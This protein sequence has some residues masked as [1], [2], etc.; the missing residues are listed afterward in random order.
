MKSAEVGFDENLDLKGPV[1][2]AAVVT[3]DSE[4][5][6]GRLIVF[7][8]SDFAMNAYFGAQG[9]GNL[10]MNVVRW[11]AQDESFIAIAAKNPA[12]R[13]LAMNESEGR[14]VSIVLVFLF[15]GAILATGL[16]VWA[17]RRK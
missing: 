10:F 14:L 5:M 1:P 16:F 15:P 12:D 9:N 3:K 13:P 17:K 7:G 11:L 8:D 2:I 4:G 6:M